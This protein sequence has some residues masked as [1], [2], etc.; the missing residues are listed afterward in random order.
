MCDLSFLLSKELSVLAKPPDPC[1]RDKHVHH[2]QSQ[3]GSHDTAGTGSA[4]D[5]DTTTPFAGRAGSAP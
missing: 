5:D 1:W 3:G 4:M 2:K